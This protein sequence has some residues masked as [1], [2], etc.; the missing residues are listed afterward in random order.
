MW[1]KKSAPSGIFYNAANVSY[2]NKFILFP[3]LMDTL[4][5]TAHIKHSTP[6]ITRVQK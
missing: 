5:Y 6:F 1:L 3:K 2:K 4:Y